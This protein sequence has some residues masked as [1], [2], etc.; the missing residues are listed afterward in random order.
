[1]KK[2]LLIICFATN[3]IGCTSVTLHPISTSDILPVNKGSIILI[4]NKE[5]LN[6]EKDG[7]F[8]S[9]FYMEEVMKARI[10]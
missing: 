5:P 3:L 9:D 7:W 8:V 1:M 10:K 2:S 4:E 6:I